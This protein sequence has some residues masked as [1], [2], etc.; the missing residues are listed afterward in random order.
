V[1]YGR[2]ADGLEEADLQ[3]APALAVSA[4]VTARAGQTSLLASA[5]DESPG[6]GEGGVGLQDLGQPRPENDDIAIVPDAL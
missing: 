5:L 1:G 2:L 3:A 6:L 4:G